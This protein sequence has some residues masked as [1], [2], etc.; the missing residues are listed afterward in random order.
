MGFVWE[1]G[2]WRLEQN[3]PPF[4]VGKREFLNQLELK[5]ALIIQTR[6][7][8]GSIK[9]FNIKNFKELRTFSFIG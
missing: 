6:S 4:M 7:S 1:V 9:N 3:F 8:F 2:S 5:I